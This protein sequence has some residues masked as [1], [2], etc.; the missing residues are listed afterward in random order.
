MTKW[1]VLRVFKSSWATT[2]SPGERKTTVYKKRWGWR[3]DLD[4]KKTENKLKISLYLMPATQMT[5]GMGDT[6]QQMT[7]GT[8]NTAL[9][10]NIS[11]NFDNSAGQLSSDVRPRPDTHIAKT[12]CEPED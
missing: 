4:S 1:R 6:S 8:V 3:C 11:T 2:T 5:A 10:E 7:A 12:A 9:Q